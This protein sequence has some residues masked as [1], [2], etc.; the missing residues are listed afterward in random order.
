MLCVRANVSLGILCRCKV[1]MM[2]RAGLGS[3]RMIVWVDRSA[4]TE[5]PHLEALEHG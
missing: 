2:V 5:W 1:L 4:Y 3:S